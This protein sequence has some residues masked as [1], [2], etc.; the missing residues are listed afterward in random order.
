[1]IKNN[2][3]ITSKRYLPHGA[4][5]GQEARPERQ[6]GAAGAPFLRFPEGL[7]YTKGRRGVSACA[8]QGFG[9]CQLRCGGEETA[10]YG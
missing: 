7:L 8:A 1:M 3:H 4:A 2:G 6:R 9:G 10:Q 5:G